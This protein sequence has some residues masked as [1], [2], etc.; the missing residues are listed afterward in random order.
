[1]RY[2]SIQSK[3]NEG[4]FFSPQLGR[5]TPSF[6]CRLVLQRARLEFSR[7]GKTLFLWI[8]FLINALDVS[9]CLSFVDLYLFSSGYFSYHRVV[10]QVSS[11]VHFFSKV[12]FFSFFRQFVVPGA[13][14]FFRRM[15]TLN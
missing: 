1:M 3:L 4:A 7:A 13:S 12:N 15:E 6:A 2:E 9:S 8:F 10:Y 11:W 14:Q 5:T